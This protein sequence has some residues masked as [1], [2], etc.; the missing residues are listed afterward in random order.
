MWGYP[1]K[2]L[3][4]MGEEMAPWH[5]WNH[6]ASL[7]WSLLDHKPHAG[8]RGL[9]TDLNRLYKSEKALHAR[10]CEGEGFEWLIADDRDNSV[11]AWLRKSGGPDAPIAVV[12]N[13]TP[14]PRGGYTLPLPQA[15]RWTEIL[16]SDSPHYGGT[17][18]G[19]AGG[20]TASATPSHGRPASAKVTLPPMAT[21][22]FRF[23]GA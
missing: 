23:D 1:G 10:D 4:F 7:D 19:N 12:T 17:G 8:M 13:F 18:M 3:L 20:I 9:I 2:K 11:F 22:I 5:E 21:L 15:G 6:A 16:N 14:V